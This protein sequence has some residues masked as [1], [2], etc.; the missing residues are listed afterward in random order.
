MAQTRRCTCGVTCLALRCPPPPWLTR[1]ARLCNYQ[2]P[3]GSIMPSS[4]QT[5]RCPPPPPSSSAP[6]RPPPP[7]SPLPSVHMWASLSVHSRPVLT[8]ALLADAAASMLL[9]KCCRA[10]HLL[11]RCKLFDFLSCRCCWQ[12]T[13]RTSPQLLSQWS[14]GCGQWTAA[15]RGCPS[16]MPLDPTARGTTASSST[17]TTTG[18]A[19]WTTHSSSLAAFCKPFIHTES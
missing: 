6:C 17:A 14:S 3:L 8:A 2:T 13:S 10:F 1:R 12:Q 11:T 15:I 7:L 16:P 4:C 18:A 9:L 19:C 5:S